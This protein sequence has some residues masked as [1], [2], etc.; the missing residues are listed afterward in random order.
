[1]YN[2]TD[3]IRYLFEVK[4]LKIILYK[5]EQLIKHV[6]RLDKDWKRL[7]PDGN[8]DNPLYERLQ[9]A[10]YLCKKRGLVVKAEQTLHNNLKKYKNLI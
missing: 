9:Y 5:D 2:I 1:M 7:Y 10:K 3:E 4:G 6:I 8:T